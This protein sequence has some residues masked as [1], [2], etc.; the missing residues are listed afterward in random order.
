MIYLVPFTCMTDAYKC[1]HIHQYPPGTE[2][3][4]STV[5]ARKGRDPRYKGIIL[6]N[7]QGAVQRY[8]IEYVNDTFFSRPKQEV[9][10][11]F[12]ST[13]LGYLGPNNIGTQHWADLHDLGYLPLTVRSLPEGSFVPYGVPCITVANTN[14]KFFWLTNYIETLL[15]SV[16]WQACTSAT[17][18]CEYRVLLEEWAEYTGS[19]QEFVDWQ[20]HDFSFR[21]MSSPESAMFSGMGHLTAFTGTDTIP[22]VKYLEHYYDATGLVGGSVPATEHSVMC[23][24]GDTDELETFSRLLDLYPTGILSVVS[25][26]WDLWHVLTVI[27]PQLKDKILA[28][29]G[30]LVIRPDSGDPVK[31]ICGDPDAPEGSPAREGVAALLW[32][33][34]GGTFTSKGYGLLDSHVGIIYGDSINLDRCERINSGLA[35]LLLASANMVYGVGSFTYQYNTRDT[36]GFAM[37]ATW[38]QINGSE[39]MLFKDPVTDDGTKRSAKGRTSVHLVDG[40][41]VLVDNQDLCAW[42]GDWHDQL[43]PVFLDGYAYCRLTLEEVRSNVR[44]EVAKRRGI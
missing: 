21:G 6:A 12:S 5:T 13:M 25:D 3:V 7:V 30:K 37:K 27:L 31:I 14:P 23:A 20:A 11:E 28:R 42:Q 39:R 16:I 40:E 29:D 32:R 10:D 26:T 34:F 17:L 4:F 1:D 19:P 35:N 9:L 36:H 44:A 8:L 38:C 18:A 22:A 41:Y 43:A 2:Y 24:G 15:S 33:T